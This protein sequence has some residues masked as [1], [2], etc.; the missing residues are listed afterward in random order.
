VEINKTETK[1]CNFQ[2]EAK[3]T[4]EE[5]IPYFEKYL[6]KQSKKIKIDGFR[7]GKAPLGMIKKLY[8]DSLEYEATEDIPNSVLSDYIKENE[9]RFAGNAQL[10]DIDYKPKEELTFKISFDYFPNVEVTNYTGLKFTKKIFKID[11]SVIKR[12]MEDLLFK[13]SEK[14]MDG[15]VLDNNYIVTA[16]IQEIDEGGSP[17][18][19]SSAKG[20]QIFVG[21]KT[22]DEN[23]HNV[24]K[25]IRENE[26]REVT[27]K[28]DDGQSHFN[29]IKA[30]KIEKLIYPEINQ[31]YL[32]RI[33]GRED[34]K[35]EQDLKDYLRKKIE[36]YYENLSEQVLEENIKSEI[37]KLNEVKIP[38]N[39]LN[40]ILEE[41]YEKYIKHQKEKHNDSEIMPKDDYLKEKRPGLIYDFKWLEITKGIIKT[42]NLQITD[43][44]KRKAAEEY[45]RSYKINIEKLIDMLSG[46]EEFI[47]KCESVMVFDFIKSKSEIVL[48]EKE[49]K[50]ETSDNQSKIIT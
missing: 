42:E 39:A 24:L 19:G 6:K 10:L 37:I 5:L 15:Q 36:E 23:L 13:T 45:S 33:F 16:D 9:I 7:P 50:E 43:E 27:L 17:I 21:D 26:E 32:M 31:E 11:D 12:E 49:I 25:D 2:I 28:Y 47:E 38:S 40:P 3:L 22:I 30:V 34:I 29:K 1:D 20:V 18:I 8:G 14:E 46:K 35:T 44:V 4:Y 41:E 48:E